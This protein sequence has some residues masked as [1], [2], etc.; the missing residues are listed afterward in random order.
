MGRE[1]DVEGSTVKKE[2]GEGRRRWAVFWTRLRAILVKVA[3]VPAGPVA[4]SVRTMARRLTEGRL[5][6]SEEY[7]ES[8]ELTRRCSERGKH[9]EG[10]GVSSGHHGGRG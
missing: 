2:E 3:V 10:K 5:S 7:K 1:S 4:K 9:A 6:T 8:R